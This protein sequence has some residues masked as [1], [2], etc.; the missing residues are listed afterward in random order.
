MPLG[1]FFTS[2]EFKRKKKREVM[3]IFLYEIEKLYCK[4]GL[5]VKGIVSHPKV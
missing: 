5:V 2:S 3:E 1:E 4:Q